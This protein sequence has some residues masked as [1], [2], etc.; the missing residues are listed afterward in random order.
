M[1][2]ML[3]SAHKFSQNGINEVKGPFMSLCALGPHL[4]HS[5]AGSHFVPW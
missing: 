2:G 5:C 4:G 3:L 1:T